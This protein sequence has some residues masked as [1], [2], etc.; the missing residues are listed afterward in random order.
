ML[1]PNLP[2]I[3]GGSRLKNHHGLPILPDTP[4]GSLLVK[5]LGLNLSS[6]F[7]MLVG[8]LTTVAPVPRGCGDRRP[9]VPMEGA[10]AL[11]LVEIK[12]SSM[13]LI[14]HMTDVWLLSPFFLGPR[15]EYAPCVS[16]CP[17]TPTRWDICCASPLI[18][19]HLSR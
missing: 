9:T 8:A 15:V 14:V 10:Q 16:A 3:G 2:N 12:A 5:G 11:V 7:A 13:T 17:R 1:V 6:T 18:L 4:I 19:E